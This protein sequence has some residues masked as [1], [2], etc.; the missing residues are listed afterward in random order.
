MYECSKAPGIFKKCDVG[1]YQL[2]KTFYRVDK[3]I[4]NSVTHYKM[5]MLIILRGKL[6]KMSIGKYEITLIN[7]NFHTI[8][9]IVYTNAFNLSSAY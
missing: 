8:Y 7:Y 9:Y 6:G 3:T 4:N 5:L 1:Q 2:G